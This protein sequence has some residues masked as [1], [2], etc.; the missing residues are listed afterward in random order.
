M[1][2]K[3]SFILIPAFAVSE[4]K[5]KGTELLVYS[6]IYGF[7]QDGESYFQGS[8]A[9]LSEWTNT[10]KECI[11]QNLISLMNKNL[12]RKTHTYINGNKL[13]KYQVISLD[14]VEKPK[15][16]TTQESCTPHTNNLVDTI[17]ESCTN[18]IV[19]NNIDNNIVSSSNTDNTNDTTTNTTT[20]DNIQ[21]VI[22]SFN[23]YCYNL[24]M[25]NVVTSTELNN[26]KLI[27]NKYSLDEIRKCFESINN[28][29]FLTGNSTDFK[30]T[31][32]WIV[33]PHNFDKIKSGK[34]KDFCKSP[35]TSFNHKLNNKNISDSPSFDMSQYEQMLKTVPDL[36]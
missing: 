29:N 1:L 33:N 4:L 32:S 26:I 12:I 35:S 20:Q 34:Y 8:L 36:F 7:S 2:N 13:C 5:L 3:H 16:D 30:A 10:S 24:D 18:N 27:L 21:K 22:D 6:I 28:N 25:A 23:C 9:Y 11:R 17:Q 14:E 19:T 31:F 15:L